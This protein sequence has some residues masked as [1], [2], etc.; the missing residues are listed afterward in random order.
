[1]R[2]PKLFLIDFETTGIDPKTARPI[3]FFGRLWDIDSGQKAESGH[4]IW[5]DSYPAITAEISGLTGIT[6]DELVAGGKP[7]KGVME[8]ILQV[9]AFTDFVVAHNGRQYDK[10]VLE[11]EAAR[12]GLTVPPVQWIDTRMDLPFPEKMRCRVLSHLALEHGYPV[13][14]GHLHRAKADVDLMQQILERYDLKEVIR[15]A[16]APFLYIRAG[17]KYDT[18]EKAKARGFRWCQYEDG[19][20]RFDN[21]WVKKIRDFQLEDERKAADFPITLLE[22][23]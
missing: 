8:Q 5:D 2:G 3:E 21:M 13:D 1:M 10:I 4:L 22:T 12:H 16:T 18:R 20:P 23:Q 6:S 15:I 9:C 7:P 17:V 14:P 19:G 11:T